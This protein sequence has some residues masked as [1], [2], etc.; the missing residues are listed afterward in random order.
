MAEEWTVRPYEP[1]DEE[2]ILP[3]FN[4]VF[5]EGNPSF[6]PRTLAHWRW[7]FADNPLGHHSYVAT[8]PEGTI[9]GSYASIPGSWLHHGEPMIGAQAVDTCVAPRFRRVLKRQGLFLSLASAYFDHYGRPDQDRIIYGFPNPVAWRIGTKRLDYRPVHTPVRAL[10][11]DFQPDWID[12]LGPMGGDRVEVEELADLPDDL[13]A[14]ASAATDGFGLIQRRDAAYLRWRYLDCPTH[15]YRLLAARAG[16]DLRGLLFFRTSW[17]DKPIAPLVDWVIRGDDTDAFCGLA[18]RAA[19]LAAAAGR[20]RL[21]TWVPLWAP[22]AA[23]LKTI[24]FAED[25]STFSLC[26]RIFGP[27]FDADWAA[28]HW[29]FTMGDSDVY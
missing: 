26:I 8:D 24:G 3:L 7:Q 13:D 22:H 2:G 28:S 12:Y 11:R 4:E 25:E 19:E 9:V 20:T 17:F 23:T 21:E 5:A 14:L 18:R 1:G 15:D 29:F 10:V 27:D 16:G 6:E